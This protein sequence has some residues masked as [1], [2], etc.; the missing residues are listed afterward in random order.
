MSAKCW[1]HC[2]PLNQT[3]RFQILEI[4]AAPATTTAPLKS[5]ITSKFTYFIM[6]AHK[7]LK[8]PPFCW[9]STQN[10][11]F[12]STSFLR[13]NALPRSESSHS[14]LPP[15]PGAIFISYFD[16]WYLPINT[17]ANKT[18]LTLT[19]MPHIVFSRF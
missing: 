6:I 14:N 1:A 18:S 4:H 8:N 5:K 12:P 16:P 15:E 13:G 19:R 7:N 3:A 17:L 9:T 10:A 2:Q 11:E